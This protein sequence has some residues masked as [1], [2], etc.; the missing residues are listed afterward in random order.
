MRNELFCSTFSACL[1]IAGIQVA[2]LFPSLWAKQKYADPGDLTV[3]LPAFP[4]ACRDSCPL[5]YM[6]HLQLLP[7]IQTD[8]DPNGLG[9][10]DVE[11]IDRNQ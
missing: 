4:K 1:W 10:P 2:D 9:R 5:Y 3:D 6:W 7:S 8:S 11:A